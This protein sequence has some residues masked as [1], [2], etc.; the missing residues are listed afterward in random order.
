MSWVKLWRELL[1]INFCY[2]MLDFSYWSAGAEW[3]W[4]S[5]FCPLKVYSIADGERN[6]YRQGTHATKATCSVICA[7]RQSW[8]AIYSNAKTYC[9]FINRIHSRF[10][11]EFLMHHIHD[12]TDFVIS[13]LSYTNTCQNTIVS[14]PI[15]NNIELFD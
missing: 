4:A 2:P 7:S 8:G 13:V 10:Y 5:C 12:N 14:F 11:C 1:I 6:A 9:I 15:N 3:L